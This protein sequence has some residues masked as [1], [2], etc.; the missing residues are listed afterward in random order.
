MARIRDEE[1]RAM[2]IRH[3]QFL[4]DLIEHPPIAMR[5]PS[6]AQELQNYERR[7]IPAEMQFILDP[8]YLKNSMAGMAPPPAPMLY[9]PVSQG[10]KVPWFPLPNGML[11]I[12]PMADQMQAGSMT[13]E[14]PIE[15]A[16][17]WAIWWSLPKN[18]DLIGWTPFGWH[19]KRFISLINELSQRIEQAQMKGQI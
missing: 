13:G 18:E 10:Q 19:Q 15:E 11:T 12:R 7:T 1:N 3:M 17:P 8:A 4:R 9:Y 2:A 14:M 6:P 16:N 5:K